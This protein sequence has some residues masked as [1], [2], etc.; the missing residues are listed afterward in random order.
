MRNRYVSM[1]VYEASKEFEEDVKE[2]Y[3]LTKLQMHR[4]GKDITDMNDALQATNFGWL[5]FEGSDRAKEIWEQQM[6]ADMRNGDFTI[7]DRLL[8]FNSGG[9]MSP[10]Q[11]RHLARTLPDG[12]TKDGYMRLLDD[13]DRLG[14]ED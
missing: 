14:N 2:Q 6:R 9:V 12:E 4:I 1:E 5:A 3:R 8:D 11:V 10:D 7:W 13:M